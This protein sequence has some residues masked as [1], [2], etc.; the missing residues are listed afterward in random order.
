MKSVKQR[1][2]K[3]TKLVSIEKIRGNYKKYTKKSLKQ[4]LK[5]GKKRKNLVKTPKNI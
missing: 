3:K 4:R 2:N 5:Q 1:K